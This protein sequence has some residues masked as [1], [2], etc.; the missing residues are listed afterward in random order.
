MRLTEDQIIV[1]AEKITEYLLVRKDKNDK[2]KF[3]MSLGYTKNNWQ[4]LVNDIKKIAL[5]NELILERS[6]EFGDLYSIKGQLK[7][8]AIITIWLEKVSHV[9]YRFITLYPDYE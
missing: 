5:N 1:P 9:S 4:E 7:T 2:S 3:L 6:S 8:K